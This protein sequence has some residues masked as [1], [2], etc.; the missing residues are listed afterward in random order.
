MKYAIVI[1]DGMADRPIASLDGR[2]PL[3][4]ADTANM[5]KVVT[6]GRLGRVKT[7]PDSHSP[8]SD[9]AIMSIVGYDPD[10]YHPGRAAL[11]AA[12]LGIE[13]GEADAVFR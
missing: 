9:T 7:V 5:D 10:R 6:R 4:L 2:T 1:P 11:E 12:N 3:E 8:G 13:I